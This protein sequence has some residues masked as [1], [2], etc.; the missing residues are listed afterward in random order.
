MVAFGGGSGIAR[1]AGGAAAS[2]RGTIGALDPE[3]S[4]MIIAISAADPN[5][6][7][8]ASSSLRPLLGNRNDD[9]GT[10]GRNG[11]VGRISASP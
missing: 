7:A 10:D 2:G 9:D 6:P 1:G 4:T 11:I 8:T 5:A 3:K